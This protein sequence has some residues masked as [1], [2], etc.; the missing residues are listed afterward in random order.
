MTEEIEKLRRYLQENQGLGGRSRKVT[1]PA[2]KAR[3][4]VSA[5]VTRAFVEIQAHHTELAAHL[6]SSIELGTTLLY[7][8]EE[9]PGW[10]F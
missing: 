10:E 6:K 1:G 4:A 9:D 2:E 7:H 3:K 8:P 5:A